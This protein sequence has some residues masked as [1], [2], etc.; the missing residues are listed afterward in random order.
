MA[1]KPVNHRF[2]TK[3]PPERRGWARRFFA[4]MGRPFRFIFRPRFRIP[5]VVP[6][7]LISLALLALVVFFA[8]ELREWALAV[9]PGPRVEAAA[10]K[11]A[12]ADITRLKTRIKNLQKQYVSFAPKRAYLIVDTSNNQYT[13]M[14]GEKLIRHGVCSTG[15][16]VL[17]KAGNDRQWVFKTPRGRFFVQEKEESPVW[18]KPDWAFIEEG[19]PVPPVG[20]PERFETG[21]LGDYALH[22]G[23][24]YL[25]HGTLYKR[26]LGMPVT[27]GCVRLDDPD[28]EVIYK[29]MAVG[30]AVFIY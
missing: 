28:L 5:R 25:I 19:L 22:L 20:A 6:A 29:N 3:T 27:H 17:L 1:D 15:S 23:H 12:P 26:L 18:H 8:P 10:A 16:Y 7:T 4:P 14:S 9:L 11:D 2:T 21:V 13:L 24:G 30:S